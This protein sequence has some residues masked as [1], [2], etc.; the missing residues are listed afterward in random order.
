[1]LNCFMSNLG[2]NKKYKETIMQARV[3][4]FS[5]KEKLLSSLTKSLLR[6]VN[7]CFCRRNQVK[8][9]KK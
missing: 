4:Q 7:H 9:P 8:L 3:L 1:M 2:R 5:F 6:R